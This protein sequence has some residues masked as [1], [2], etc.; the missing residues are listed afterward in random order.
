MV[1]AFKN[2]RYALPLKMGPI[3]CSET[4]VRNYH[5]KLLKI[6]KERESLFTPRGKP[7]MNC[8]FFLDEN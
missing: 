4:W 1:E 6:P 7:E 5:S 8:P 3:G 2:G